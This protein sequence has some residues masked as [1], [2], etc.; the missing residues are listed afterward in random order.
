MKKQ[1]VR[2]LISIIFI[3]FILVISAGQSLA[4]LVNTS[5][6]LDWSQLSIFGSLDWTSQTT[7]TDTAVSNSFGENEA[8]SDQKPGW[9]STSSAVTISNG[10]A[11]GI[12]TLEQ[13]LSAVSYSSLADIGWSN[14]S[15]S[16]VLTGSFTATATGWVFITIP[17]SISLD[18]TASSDPAAS[19]QG[20]SKAIDFTPQNRWESFNRL[21]GNILYCL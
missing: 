11:Q 10:G 14:S 17:Y 9:V 4:S 5:A 20:S 6:S 19:A 15:G 12:S 18:L 13:S 16:S 8:V 7:N 3:G 1:I 2:M 21:D